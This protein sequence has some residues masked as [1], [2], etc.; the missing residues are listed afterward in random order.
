MKKYIIWPLPIV[1]TPGYRKMI[2]SHELFLSI[3]YYDRPRKR[4][5][6]LSK[7]DEKQEVI[8]FRFHAHNKGTLLH[9]VSLEE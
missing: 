3:T 5:V 4:D 2:E 9:S 6:S 8:F 7:L 1:S